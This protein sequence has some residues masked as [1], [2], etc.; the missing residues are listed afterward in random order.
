M[1]QSLCILIIGA[2]ITLSLSCKKSGLSSVA[3]SLKGTWQLHES[4]VSIMPDS[5]YPPGN[6]NM[7]SFDGIS[8]KIFSKG[9]L[10]RRGTY[11]IVSYG[12]S[13]GSF[14][15]MVPA[16]QSGNRIVYDKD[17]TRVMNIK[18]SDTELDTEAGCAAVDGQSHQKYWRVPGDA[19][20]Q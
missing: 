8:Y 20:M 12:P 1:K 6:G 11:E 3:S 5:V 9:Q 14:C 7:L 16:G 10:I 2:L 19:P 4:Q 13:D 15:S 17:N 18:V